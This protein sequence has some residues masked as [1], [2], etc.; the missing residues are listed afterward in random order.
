MG[1]MRYSVGAGTPQSTQDRH[2]RSI[3]QPSPGVRGSGDDQV[4]TITAP[5]HADHGGVQARTI[6]DSG[7]SPTRPLPRSGNRFDVLGE[8]VQQRASVAGVVAV[9]EIA[10]R[11]VWE[12]GTRSGTR[13]IRTRR[14]SNASH[15][16]SGC[17]R[18]TLFG[19]RETQAGGQIVRV[20]GRS[21][22][23]PSTQ[24]AWRTTSQ[25]SRCGAG[26]QLHT[27]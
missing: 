3:V 17:L 13:S 1:W 9:R 20:L 15:L 4:D 11:R 10:P 12:D 6:R 23:F 27:G 2:E 5:S 26:M 21:V 7:M 14:P 25:K 16:Q 19:G 18:L 22:R 24:D 8:T